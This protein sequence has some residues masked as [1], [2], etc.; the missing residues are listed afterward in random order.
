MLAV[1]ALKAEARPCHLKRI[2]GCAIGIAVDV[3]LSIEVSDR[4]QRELAVGAPQ[5][6]MLA[7]PSGR[8]RRRI[9]GLLLQRTDLFLEGVDVR[10]RSCCGCGRRRWRRRRRCWLAAGLEQPLDLR[11]QL[12]H[13]AAQFLHVVPGRSLGRR[14]AGRLGGLR[15]GQRTG[16]DA[17]HDQE[18]TPQFWRVHGFPL[19]LTQK[20]SPTVVEARDQ[21]VISPQRRGFR[22]ATIRPLNDFP[23]RLDSPVFV[24]SVHGLQTEAIITM[25]T[26]VGN[27]T[28]A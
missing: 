21:A 20:F 13:L 7:V 18:H 25:K 11:P 28:F 6:E 10:A 4:H 9:A 15:I 8:G 5:E 23:L 14:V 27:C 3:V 22:C 16:R 2:R 12:L 17:K 24:V 1:V 19:F 26:R